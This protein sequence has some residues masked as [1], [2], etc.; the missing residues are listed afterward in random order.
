MRSLYPLEQR[1]QALSG[2]YTG[3]AVESTGHAQSK[4]AEI[5]GTLL[6]HEATVTQTTAS[7]RL[8]ART[9]R[10]FFRL[11]VDPLKNRRSTHSVKGAAT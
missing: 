4:N 7:T 6:T 10:T 5:G 3:V 1:H 2:K 11:Y 9:R 8:S